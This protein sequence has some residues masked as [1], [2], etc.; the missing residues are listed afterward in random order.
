ME[1]TVAK[2][3]NF[4][5]MMFHPETGEGKVFKTAG[6]VPEGY[7]SFHPKDPARKAKDALEA[8][9]VVDAKPAAAVAKAVDIPMTR[10][11][12]IAALN[13]GGI[14]FDDNA[15][16]RALHN[17]LRDAVHAALIEAKISYVDNA[18]TKDLLALLP[19]PA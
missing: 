17:Q 14:P 9:K 3:L 13:S 2:D 6:E 7:L 15:K 5:A 1:T 18:P 8:A 11:E 19:D 12:I 4:P 10:D 16:T